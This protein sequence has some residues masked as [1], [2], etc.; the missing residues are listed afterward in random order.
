M[1]IRTIHVTLL[2]SVLL[3]ALA[4]WQWVPQIR[5]LLSPNLRLD[6]PAP[7]DMRIEER[8]P[9]P[10]PPPRAL[11]PQPRPA[12][13]PPIAAPRPKRVEPAPQARP[14]QPP[15]PMTKPA[16]PTEP[17][18]YAVQEPAPPRAPPPAPRAGI[19]GDFASHVEARRRARQQAEGGA[20][21]RPPPAPAEESES[22]RASRIAAAN[23][24][25]GQKPRFGEAPNGGGIF[26]L[27]RVTYD[28]AEYL[29]FGWNPDI[30]RN[31]SQLITV[32]KGT[33]ADIRR[34]VVRSMIDIIRRH[35]QGD[36]LWESRRL[37]RDVMLSARP[38][39]DAGL[40]GFLM[41]E[42]FDE[43]RPPA[44]RMP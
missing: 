6:E 41:K 12:P 36:F 9:P 37:G 38:A 30:R 42:F 22:E 23:L 5:P 1:R 4:L 35:E 11:P 29:F 17:P 13:E 27:Q 16:A 14:V 3:H 8:A 33:H 2:L 18:D 21:A 32:R 44:A 25:L 28:Y 15:P 19:E 26:Q 43:G 34:A 31:A 10:S 24:G 40:E 7:F 20:P 39:D